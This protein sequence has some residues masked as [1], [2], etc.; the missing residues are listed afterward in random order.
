MAPPQQ[1]VT[2]KLPPGREAQVRSFLEAADFEIAEADHAFYRARGRGVTATFYRSGKLVVQGAAAAD[3]AQAMTGEAAPGSPGGEPFAEGIA[4]LPDPKPQAWIGIDET[5]KGDYFGPLV[6]VA[7]RVENG[8]LPLLAELGVA[9][10]KSMSDVAA[11]R[12]AG[13]LKAVVPHHKLVLMPR[14]Y[15]DL[16]ARGMTTEEKFAL[17]LRSVS[18]FMQQDDPDIQRWPLIHPNDMEAARVE[19]NRA[20]RD[21]FWGR[22]T[23]QSVAW[24]DL[25]FGTRRRRLWPWALAGATIVGSA[26]AYY[27]GTR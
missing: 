27:Y 6:V 23:G 3:W 17:T 9:D 11:K 15:N 14:K 10:S 4:R 16:Y 8:Q 13:D 7:A 21:A 22:N 2:L 18:L 5:G 25:N 24:A 1:T 12:I 26:A 20:T 19:S